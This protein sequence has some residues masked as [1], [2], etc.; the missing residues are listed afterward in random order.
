MATE[1]RLPELGENIASGTIAKVLVAP[2]DVIAVDQSVIEVETDKAVAEI[3]ATLAGKITEVKVQEGSEVRPGDVVLLVEASAV[4]PAPEAPVK[5]PE[6]AAPVPPPS[7]PRAKPQ[8]ARKP[9]APVLASPSVRRLARELGVNLQD[10]PV[11]APTGRVT[12]QEIRA[13]AEGT[14]QQAAPPEAPGKPAPAAPAASL[15]GLEQGQD[16]Y[17][18]VAYEPMNTVRRKTAEHMTHAWTTIPHVTHF[19][20][21]DITELEVFRKTQAGAVEAAGGKLTTIAFIVRVVAGALKRF[22]KFNASLDPDGQRLV[23]KQ[24]CHVGVA[25]DTPTGL[26]VPVL[27]DADRKS[28]RDIAIEL[29]QLAAKARDRK[30]A[31]EDMQGGTFTISNLGGLGGTG[32]TPVIN[33]PEVAIL[34][35]SRASTEAAYRDGQWLPH[36][37]L[38]LSLSYDHRVIDGADAARF[39]RWVAQALEQPWN[40]FLDV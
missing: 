26:L 34:G 19:D 15:E 30:L 7:P 37:M 27:R 24:Y 31:I 9:G 1:F 17:G 29:P 2:G 18:P 21:A 10:V 4:A 12:A 35:V 20:K 5:P 16:S 32:F 14:A 33:A 3:P 28:A 8:E 40:M 22:P 13:F 38:P 25:V 11:S 6:Q 39:T 23:L 36:T